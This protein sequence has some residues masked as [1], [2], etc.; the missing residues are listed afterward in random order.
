MNL[1]SI[2]QCTQLMS[3]RYYRHCTSFISFALQIIFNYKK[4]SE[5]SSYEGIFHNSESQSPTWIKDFK[6][7]LARSQF[8]FIYSIH[9]TVSL[10]FV[11]AIHRINHIIF[12]FC[13][14]FENENKCA[15]MLN[16]IHICQDIL[17]WFCR[18]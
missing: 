16:S 14:Q 17:D 4:V 5:F 8:H 12:T 18:H 11:M 3:N 13:N 6:Q 9:F 15:C 1:H 10:A 7:F 2:H